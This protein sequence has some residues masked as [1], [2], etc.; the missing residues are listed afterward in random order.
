MPSLQEILPTQG[1]NPRLL[2]RQEDSLPLK[3]W[4][5]LNAYDHSQKS[6]RMQNNF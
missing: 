3:L 6:V 1:S 5:L 4:N 2:H